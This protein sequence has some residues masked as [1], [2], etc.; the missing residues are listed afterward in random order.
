MNSY[1][2][3]PSYF[4]IS[5]R[6]VAVERVD[7]NGNLLFRKVSRVNH[8]IYFGFQDDPSAPLGESFFVRME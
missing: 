6:K 7:A 5:S 3:P 4:T 8:V 2:F 1:G